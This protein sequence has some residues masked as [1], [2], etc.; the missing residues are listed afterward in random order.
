MK[1]YIKK[2]LQPK[3]WSAEKP[4]KAFISFW[5]RVRFYPEGGGQPSDTGYLND[6][7]VKEVHEKEGELLHY[8]DQPME[9]GTEVQGRID[10]AR[11]FDLMQ[12]HSGEHMVS[13]LI[14]EAYGYDNVGFHMGSDTITI[15]LNGPLDEAQ[16]AE[17]EVEKQTKKIMGRYADK[18]HI[19]YSEEL[20]KIDYRSKKETYRSGADRRISRGGYLCLLRNSCDTYWRDRNGEAP[21]RGKIP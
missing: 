17:I 15:D 20:E 18:D 3:S 6:V 13:G 9:A 1:M 11:R 12:Q 14:H 5:M 16:L 8:T 7:K 4:K 21:F 2:N 19:S 10:W